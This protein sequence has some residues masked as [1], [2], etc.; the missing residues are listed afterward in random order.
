MST[1]LLVLAL[2]LDGLGVGVS[3]GLRGI[4]LRW[5]TY[6]II[7]ACTALLMAVSMAAG[8]GI[9][10]I[11]S[12]SSARLAGGIVLV[13]V[14]LWQLLQTWR[15]YRLELGARGNPKPVVKVGIPYLGLVIQ[16]LVEPCAADADRSGD[17]DTVEA[18][19][20]GTALGLD[21]LGAGLGAAMAG[22][23]VALVPLVSAGCIAFVGLGLILGR[24]PSPTTLARRAGTL[25]GL[26][27][28]GLGLLRLW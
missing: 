3:Y 11:V 10:R 24:R 27:L 25:P 12:P 6:L 28:V 7:G 5:T 18:L 20:V 21:A 15:V 13:G 26:I 22:F 17:I 1:A 8:E 16:I 19:A 2:S 9:T 14:G 4:R 23:P